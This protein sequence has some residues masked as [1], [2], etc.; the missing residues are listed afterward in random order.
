MSVTH[1][2]NLII[3][4][5]SATGH[6]QRLDKFLSHQLTHMSRSQIKHL[7]E[8]G[9]TSVTPITLKKIRSSLNVEEGQVWCLQIPPPDSSEIIPEDLPLDILYEDDDIVVVNKSP[10]MVV[11]PGA[12]HPS[13]TL[14][15]GLSYRYPEIKIGSALRPGLVHRLDKETSGVMVVAR[16]EIA[17]RVLSAAFAQRQVKKNYTLF[18][19]GRPKKAQ[20]SLKTGHKRHETDRR[21]FTTRLEPPLAEDKGNRFAHTDFLLKGTA[22]GVSWLEATLHTGRTHQIRAHMTDLGHPLLMDALYGGLKPEKRIGSGPVQWAA[23]RLDRQALHAALLS[24]K[25]P[26]T[27]EVCTF[28]A[29]LPQ[30]LVILQTAISDANSI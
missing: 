17:H 20:F 8:E 23:K 10:H 14:V 7:I 2:D 16:T 28:E 26:N 15:N 29:P 12:G 19:Y 5:V 18:C 24:F 21:R 4:D 1:D 6:G 22:Q 25:H 9:Y 30:D 11:H 13:G 27:N 3:I